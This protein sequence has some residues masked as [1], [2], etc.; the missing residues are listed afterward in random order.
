[1]LIFIHEAGNSQFTFTDDKTPQ[2]FH[3][4]VM[5]FSRICG[6]L[7]FSMTC[8]HPY[9]VI[10]SLNTWVINVKWRFLFVYW[11]L[12]KLCIYLLDSSTDEEAAVNHGRSY[13]LREHRPRVSLYEAPP[14]G[15]MFFSDLEIF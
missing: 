14:I 3:S 12:Q 13:D 11:S 7:L 10:L 6:F 2:F 4:F 9:T 5:N 15:K 1:M 8:Y